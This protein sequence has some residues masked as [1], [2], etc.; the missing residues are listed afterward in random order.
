M[1]R[2]AITPSYYTMEVPMLGG[3][4]SMCWPYAWTAYTYMHAP[5]YC[6]HRLE[7]ITINK[8][9]ECCSFCAGMCR[10]QHSFSLWAV[11][12]L[13]TNVFLHS[14][15]CKHL[16]ESC[17]T[18]RFSITWRHNIHSYRRMA[19]FDIFSFAWFRGYNFSDDKMVL[20]QKYE[21]R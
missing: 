10:H 11:E 18:E 9:P 16:L 4:T 15:T 17:I 13:Q 7:N 3:W 8:M 20:Q 1:C 6:F 19:G 5:T 14:C 12:R 21:C 2:M